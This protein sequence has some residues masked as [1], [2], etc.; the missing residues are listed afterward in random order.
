[1][2]CNLESYFQEKGGNN[3][4]CVYPQLLKH[5]TGTTDNY[6]FLSCYFK[7]KIMI[8]RNIEFAK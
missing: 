3:F 7:T 8:P 1:M 4:V 6:S 2:I 5:N